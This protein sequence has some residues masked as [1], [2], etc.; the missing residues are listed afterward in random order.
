MTESDQLSILDERL[1]RRKLN[2]TQKFLVFV[3][4]LLGI[5]LLLFGLFIFSL[6][7]M[8]SDQQVSGEVTVSSNWI[9]ITPKEPMKPQKQYQNLVLDAAEPLMKDNSDLENIRFA[10]GSSVHLE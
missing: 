7:R 4:V 9:V 6:V 10:D 2:F 3:G 5:C 8:H 1:P